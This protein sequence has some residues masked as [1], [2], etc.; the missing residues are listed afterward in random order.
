M[1]LSGSFSVTQRDGKETVRCDWTG[2]QNVTN[3]TTAITAKL[4]FTNQYEIDIGT[5]THTITIDGTA[6]NITSNAINTTGEHYLGSVTHTVVHNSDGAKSIAMS[7]VFSLKATLSGT[8]YESMSKSTSF[9]L[10]TIPRVSF[11]QF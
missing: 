4:Y 2:T 10:N 5:R 3:N 7:F 8:Y 9:S 1:A 6:Y 11:Q